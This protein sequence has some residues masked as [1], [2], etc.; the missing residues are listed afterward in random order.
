[1]D[2]QKPKGKKQDVMVEYQKISDS[3]KKAFLAFAKQAGILTNTISKI[4]KYHPDPKVRRLASES[5]RLCGESLDITVEQIKLTLM[6]T[7]I[8]YEPVLCTD[9]LNKD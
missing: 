5:L 2:D 7:K 6:S 8:T 3:T 9:D 1:M 4:D